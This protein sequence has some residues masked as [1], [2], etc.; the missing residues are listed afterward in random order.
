VWT[1]GFFIILHQM[2]KSL[3]A[4]KYLRQYCEGMTHKEVAV[5]NKVREDSVRKVFKALR[6]KYEAKNMGEL[7]KN[8]IVEG[9]YELW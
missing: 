7:I 8:V 9:R 2:G 5:K 3:T 1:R 4:I 6:N